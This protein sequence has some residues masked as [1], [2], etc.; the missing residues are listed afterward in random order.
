MEPW[1]Q[2][3]NWKASQPSNQLTKQASNRLTNQPTKEYYGTLLDESLASHIEIRPILF[4]ETTI[5]NNMS[6]TGVFGAIQYS[7]FEGM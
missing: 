1:N 7:A 4:S 5:K 2:A 3:I 6:D